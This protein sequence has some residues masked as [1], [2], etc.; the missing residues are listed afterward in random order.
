MNT[1][2]C[3]AGKERGVKK[4]LGPVYLCP[5]AKAEGAV[6]ERSCVSVLYVDGRG[7]KKEAKDVAQ[8][9]KAAQHD[10]IQIG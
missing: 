3:A 5:Q 6:Q 1:E 7:R 2:A 4:G 10:A 9:H 8:R